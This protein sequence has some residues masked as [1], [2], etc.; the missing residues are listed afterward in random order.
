MSFKKNVIFLGRVNDIELVKILGSAK[1]LCFISF[2]EG[3]GL[4][5]VEA[6]K[7]SVPVIAS[8]ITCIPEITK[9]AA[10]LINPNNT[11]EITNAMIE[12]EKNEKTRTL[13]IEK[14]HNQIKKFDWSLSANKVWKIM[15]SNTIN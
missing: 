6:M 8:N 1:A 9:D 4:P 12:I 2:F 7:C 3:F 5:I 15:K 11:Q 13:C 10:I 14:G